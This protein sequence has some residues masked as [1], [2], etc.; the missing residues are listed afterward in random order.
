VTAIL[1]TVFTIVIHTPI[2]VLPLYALLLFLGFQRTRDST[3]PLYRVL[4]LPL[5]VALLATLTFIGAGAGGLPAML[6]GLALGSAAG[7]QLEHE[8]ATR[9][10]VDGRVWL[11]G[12]LWSFSQLV[13]VLIFRYATSAAGGMDPALNAN[14][15]WH[16]TTLGISAGLS[17]LFLGRA[18]A[19][20]RVYFGSAPA[21]A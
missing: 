12:E 11:R 10:L 1:T 6:T 9:R 4:I 15:V 18:A 16:L 17:G 20:L 5:V 13:V 8:G 21:I 3:V 14:P 7:W 19:R 2:W